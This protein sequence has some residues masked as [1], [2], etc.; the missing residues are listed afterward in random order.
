[1]V[2]HITAVPELH[3]QPHTHTPK[4]SWGRYSCFVWINHRN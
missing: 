1:M 2:M 4:P 3:V